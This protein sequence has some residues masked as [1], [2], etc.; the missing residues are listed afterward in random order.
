MYLLNF[1]YDKLKLKTVIVLIPRN[2]PNL[3]SFLTPMLGLYGINVKEFINEV[4]FRLKF[5]NEITDIIVPV[6]VVITKIKTF[7]LFFK[8]PYVSNLLAL[9]EF[10]TLNL[11]VVYKLLQVKVYY[12][13]KF[14][15]CEQ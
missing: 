12:D 5:L 4:E 15:I 10:K 13:N 3:L 7:F 11:L 6:E 9:H 2:H 8:P 1:E 14:K